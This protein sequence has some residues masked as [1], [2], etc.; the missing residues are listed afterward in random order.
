MAGDSAGKCERDGKG[1]CVERES[2]RVAVA[3]TRLGM[4]VF[5]N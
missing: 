4:P 5:G 3:E 2:E 1:G